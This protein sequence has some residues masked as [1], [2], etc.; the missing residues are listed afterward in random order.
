[1]EFEGALSDRRDANPVAVV[2]V[3]IHI[4]NLLHQYEAAIGI[5]TYAQQHLGV[6]LKESWYEKLQLWDDSLKA[7]TAKV[8]QASSPHLCLD[9]T[10]A[11]WEELNNLCK[12]YWTPAELE[13]APMDQMA[14]YVSRLDMV[15]KPNSES[16]EILLLAVMEVVMAP[17]L[18]P[19]S[20]SSREG[21]PSI[22]HSFIC[23]D[24][25]A[26]SARVIFVPAPLLPS[27]LE[28][29]ERAYNKTVHVQQLSELEEVIEY[30]T[31]PHMGNLL[32]EGKRALFPNMWNERIK[33]A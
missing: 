24:V 9:A 6:Q 17:F 32:V 3:L 8:S 10:L 20:S 5:L 16:W 27:V 21:S 29:Y 14:E 19:S 11:R 2:V 15:M 30:C 25:V 22:F 4:N 1:M 18:G 7:Y 31:L 13:M 23:F 12:E 26:C 28:S 33:G